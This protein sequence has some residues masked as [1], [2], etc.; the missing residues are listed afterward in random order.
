MVLLL[1]MVAVAAVVETLAEQVDKVV[2]VPVVLQLVELLLK[3]TLEEVVVV[4]TAL[5]D[6]RVDPVLL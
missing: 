1:T 6:M 3:L 2:V 5:A 4:C